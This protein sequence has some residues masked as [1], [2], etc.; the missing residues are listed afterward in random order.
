MR[1]TGRWHEAGSNAKRLPRG[2]TPSAGQAERR[3]PGSRAEGLPLTLPPTLRETPSTLDDRSGPKRRPAPWCTLKDTVGP[4]GQGLGRPTFVHAQPSPWCVGGERTGRRRPTMDEAARGN[5]APTTR[6][7]RH[8]QRQTRGDDDQRCN[9]GRQRG[10]GKAE[11]R[12]GPLCPEQIGQAEQAAAAGG[13]TWDRAS[14]QTWEGRSD[15][16]GAWRGQ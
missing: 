1:G 2:G 4:S 5:R 16:A 7:Q 6:G 14:G 13:A 8:R 9:D 12:W 10:W 11:R 3:T 15:G